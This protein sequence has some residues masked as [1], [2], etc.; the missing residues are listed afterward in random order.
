VRDGEQVVSPMRLSLGAAGF[1]I[2]PV[3][4]AVKDT[5]HFALTVLQGGK[6]VAR[7]VWSD[8][9][10]EAVLDLPRGEVE[11]QPALLGTD[12]KTLLQGEPLRLTVTRSTP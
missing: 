10:T 11:L 8:G 9:R 2:A 6:T 12:G 7:H 1:G 5:G 3:D 4:K